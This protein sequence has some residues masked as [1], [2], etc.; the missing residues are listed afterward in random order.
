MSKISIPQQLFAYSFVVLSLCNT[1]FICYFHTIIN[2]FF[3]QFCIGRKSDILLLNDGVNLNFSFCFVFWVKRNALTQ[4]KF[5]SLFPNSLSKVYKITRIKRLFDLKK[6]FSRKILPIR[7]LN[8]SFHYTFIAF[9]K[10]L[11]K[12]I[13]EIPS[14]YR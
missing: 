7:I 6:R 2:H 14:G 5:L 3:C 8:P 9:F 12:Q 1:L 4:K 10:H 13:F 11:L